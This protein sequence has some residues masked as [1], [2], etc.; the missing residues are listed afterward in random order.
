MA[1]VQDTPIALQ[2][3][4]VKDA[5]GQ[6]FFG[7]LKAVKEMGYDG[8]EFAGF[9]DKTP[10]E[11]KKVLADLDLKI[12]GSHTGFGLLEGDNFENT[13]SYSKALGNTR[14]VIPSMPGD[15][16]ADGIAGWK[17]QTEVMKGIQE[18]LAAMGLKT[19]FH[20]HAVEFEPKEGTTAFDTIFENT[21]KDFIMQIDIGWAF[22]AGADARDFFKKYP[23]RSE[24]V[25]VKAYAA[26]ND[27]A[28]VGED[29]VPW[30]DVLKCA[31]EVG[32]T[33]WFI[34]EHERHE[35][36]PLN[37]VRK[38]LDYLRSL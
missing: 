23:G 12:A 32:K 21:G 37:N 5:C 13:T 30:A 2:L 6:D 29:D 17:K 3:W 18:K 7:T 38:C 4:S 34:V 35:G 10:E 1:S 25:H 24:T 20:N 28:C 27:T 26:D 15:R 36:D 19:G 33:E 16:V 8:V 11:L 31:V 14:L 22:R 9:Y